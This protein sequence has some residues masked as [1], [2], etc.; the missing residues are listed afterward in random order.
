LIKSLYNILFNK[1]YKMAYNNDNYKGEYYI[2]DLCRYIGLNSS[3]KYYKSY[4]L[5]CLTQKL[6]YKYGRYQ[7]NDK[8]IELINNHN[9]SMGWDHSVS[10]AHLTRMVTQMKTTTPDKSIYIVLK[11][12]EEGEATEQLII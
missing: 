1:Y 4:I 12:F 8:C 10:K 5:T 11:I 2:S 7:L 9:I 6:E 3:K